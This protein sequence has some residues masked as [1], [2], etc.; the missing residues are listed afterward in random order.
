MI[1]VIELNN[2]KGGKYFNPN[3]RNEGNIKESINSIDLNTKNR[4]K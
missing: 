2:N 1:I 4:V 3:T